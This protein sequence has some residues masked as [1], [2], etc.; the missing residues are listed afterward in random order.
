M[1]KLT[2]IIMFGLAVVAAFSS[3]NIDEVLTTPPPPSITF[4]NS[5]GIY[6]TKQG[7]EITIAP[8]YTNAE[9]ATFSWSIGTETIST[10]PALTFIFD[11][12][13][14]FY[15]TLTV[16]TQ[17]GQTRE[18]IRVDVTSLEIP[19][20]TIMGSESMT[21]AVGSVVDL[22][23]SVRKTGLPTTICWTLNGTTTS[24]QITYRFAAQECGSHTII[25]TATNEDGSHSDT[26]T[27]NVLQPEDMPLKW[28]FAHTE[29]HTVEGRRILI[30]PSESSVPDNTTYTWQIEGSEE[31]IGRESHFIYNAT[32]VGLQ[33]LIATATLNTNDN[34]TT[35]NNIFNIEVLAE[36]TYIRSVTETSTPNQN[37]VYDYTPAP[38]QFINELKTG[39]FDGTQTTPVAACS[40]AEE[41]MAKGN[42][43]SL[44]GFGG[45]IVVG[46]DH[47]IA[48]GDS[49]DIAIK[50]NAFNGSSEPGIVW[51]MQDEN[52]NSLPDD[53]W[54]ELKGSDTHAE[55]TIHEYSVTY[56]RPSGVGMPVGWTD[57]QG[58]SGEVDYL[59]QYHSQDYYYPAWIEAD[60]YT[61]TGTRLEARN[62]DKS[63]NGSNWVQPHYDWGYAD[64]F[65][66]TDYIS[67]NKVNL[68]DISNA[69]D[70]DGAEISLSHI[71]FVKVQCGVNAKSGW[72]GEL[73]T[74]VSGFID[75]N[76]K[77]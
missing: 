65:S 36:D 53:T 21:V 4:D 72:V 47:S 15:V 5:T 18:D 67:A 16:T 2:E 22:V 27:I 28:E 60:S 31:I 33:R 7:R 69:I 52:G 77:K 39:G 42:W 3:C 76:L 58:G 49:H 64:N 66:P 68:F 70:F 20:I 17:A 24:E 19:T 50:C 56:Y 30:R 51:V 25:A 73:S 13:G 12:E 35:L 63:G 48:N 71:D 26:V 57:N 74:E 59:V 44:G 38:G 54:Y 23:A 34:T 37:K 1:R 61:L 43:V 14:T 6:T 10:E 40:Y 55:S 62:Y 45:Y 32:K 9:G 11:N 41:R 46:F 8:S 75:Y 29:L